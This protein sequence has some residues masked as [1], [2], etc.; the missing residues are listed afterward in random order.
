MGRGFCRLGGVVLGFL[1]GYLGIG[2]GGDAECDG[3][4]GSF[5]GG[6]D[7]REEKRLPPGSKAR[8]AIEA[9]FSL[10]F[11]IVCSWRNIGRDKSFKMNS[12]S[13][14]FSCSEEMEWTMSVGDISFF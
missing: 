9:Q 4:V 13:A 12:F 3:V 10:Q 11:W 8:I 5:G 1:G 14:F 2:M 7:G 6:V